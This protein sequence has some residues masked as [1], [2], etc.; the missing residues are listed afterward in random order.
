[1]KRP[2]DLNR[3]RGEVSAVLRYRTQIIVPA[4]R[5]IGLQLPASLPEGPATVIVQVHEEPVPGA[6]GAC[7]ET[8]PDREDIEWWEEFEDTPET[9]V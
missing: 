3:T 2:V 1:M 8:D 9:A 5:Y 4:D 7:D 6:P